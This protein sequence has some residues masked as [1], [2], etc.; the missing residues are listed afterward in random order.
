M[1]S[2]S[3]V[4]A[5]II[6]GLDADPSRDF[7]GHGR[8][9]DVLP[10]GDPAGADLLDSGG[11]ANPVPEPIAGQGCRA[12]FWMRVPRGPGSGTQPVPRFPGR[13]SATRF[14]IRPPALPSTGGESHVRP[15]R[16]RSGTIGGPT[17]LCAAGPAPPVPQRFPSCGDF[18]RQVPRGRVWID[19]FLIAND[20]GLCQ[21]RIAAAVGTGNHYQQWHH[22]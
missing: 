5:P 16:F 17:T 3:P 6:A 22:R 12:T 14:D 21:R 2:L 1:V 10:T 18:G 4:A 15:E 8:G 9:E 7:L 11:H 13:H 20:S 19:W